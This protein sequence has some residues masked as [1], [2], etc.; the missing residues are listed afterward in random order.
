M[1]TSTDWWPLG[2]DY[3]SNWV[4]H[5]QPDGALLVDR[6]SLFY[7][8][9]SGI[10]AELALQFSRAGGLD[11]VAQVRSILDNED[12]QSAHTLLKELLGL[13]PVTQ[14]WLD[15]K[16]N[17]HL[18]TSGSLTSF[19]PL[20]VSL[21]LTN[22][23]NLTCPFCYASSGSSRAAKFSAEEWIRLIQTMAT[24]CNLSVMLNGGEPTM[25]I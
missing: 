18:H 11:E 13:H 17:S 16:L 8:R 21:Q 7:V 5:L 6:S 23:C 3:S 2:H 10:A 22:G 24:R 15:G 1:S 20:S 4:L 12:E 9:L 19:I 25:V 14:E